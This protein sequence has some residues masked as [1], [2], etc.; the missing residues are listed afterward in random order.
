V[1]QS[2]RVKI[3]HNYLKIKNILK[4]SQSFIGFRT[5]VLDLGHRLVHKNMFKIRLK[6]FYTNE[7]GRFSGLKSGANESVRLHQN[8]LFCLTP[9]GTT[10]LLLKNLR[11]RVMSAPVGFSHGFPPDP[12]H[13]R[14]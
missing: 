4:L 2:F 12:T 7:F 11:L 6:P 8:R 5:F 14:H 10:F 1:H 13:S 9:L 3:T